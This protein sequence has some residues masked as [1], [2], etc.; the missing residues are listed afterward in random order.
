MKQGLATISLILLGL[1]IV[2]LIL[3]TV[4]ESAFLGM[5]TLAERIVTFAL[6]VLPAGIGA[7]AGVIVYGVHVCRVDARGED[8]RD[9]TT[10]QP[11]LVA[12]RND[13]AE[14]V[15][16]RRAGEAEN[17]SWDRHASS[18]EASTLPWVGRA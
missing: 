15:V 10:D 8:A 1:S 7:I 18:H 12:R 9:A 5:S 13:D 11:L 16:R 17:R 6:L 2:F 3:W 14:R 4:S